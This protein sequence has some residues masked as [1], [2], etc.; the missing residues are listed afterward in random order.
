MQ[1][2]KVPI[3]NFQYGEVSPSLI[4]RT[5]SE[6]YNSSA[7]RV[8]NFFLR[9][10][11]G[12][13]KR[14]GTKHIYT[15]D[16]TLNENACTITVADYANIAVGATITLTTS[17]GVE[18][19]FTAEAAGASDPASS[20]GFRP[21]T[22]NNTTADNIYTTINAHASFTVANPSAAVIT[23]TETSPSP[24]GFLTAKSSDGT[25]LAVT[26]ES[27]ARTQ[28]ARLVPFIFSDDERYI[29]SLENAKI[30][31]FSIDTSDAVT[32]VSTI[33][34][35]TDSA[36]VPFADTKLHELV[37]AQSGDNM[38]ITHQSFPIKKLV[39]TSLTAFE[40]QTFEFASNGDSTLIFQPYSKFHAAGLTI[41]PSAASGSGITVTASAA[42]FTSNHVGV[43][44]RYHNSEIL[45]TGFTNATT[46]TGTVQGNLQQQLDINALRTTEGSASIEV[47]HVDHGLKVGDG[48]IVAE[49]A[50]IATLAASNIN[51]TR[52]ITAIVDENR[53]RFAA[54]S[55]TADAS[56][57][58]GGAPKITTHAATTQFSEQS[59]SLVRG[60][61]ACVSFH[62]NRL[63]FGGTESQP[64]TV[65][66]SKSN[67]FFNFDVGTAADDDAI[68]LV[69]SIGEINT[70]RHIVSNRD[71][72]VF[73][74]T[75]EFYVPSFQNS[76]IT[77]TNAQIKRQTPFGS[78]FV[79]PFVFDGAT[80]Y[81]QSSGKS[82]S[83]YI[84]AD[85]VNAYTSQS[86]ST[87]SSHLIKTPHQMVVLQGSLD[88]PESYLFAVNSDGTIAVFNSNPA[89]KKAGWTE[90]TT[91]GIFQSVCVVDTNLYVTAWYDT[92]AG[93]KK[94]YLMQ[95]D[96]T[97]NLDL[98]RDYVTSAVGTIAGVSSDWVN[99]A[100]LDVISDTDYVGQF[101]MA[102][103]KIVTTTREDVPINTKLEIG[104]TFPVE[105]KTNPIDAA[106]QNG[107]LTGE[108]RSVNKVIVDMNITGSI[109]INGSNLIIRQT[110]DDFSLGRKSFT[111]KKEFRLLGYSKDPQVTITQEAPLSLQVNGIVA[112]VT[113]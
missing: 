50:T 20:T 7:Q 94:L 93:T 54:A 66:S 111:G 68:E 70:I 18:V 110:T 59:Y 96:A 42:Y 40:L 82:I 63:W 83:Q 74:S 8:Q 97:K 92:G 61:P 113:F 99:G 30:R 103:N 41:D 101:T 35:D 71:L 4:A 11:G 27:L 112:E 106:V 107:S 108:P 67:D 25:R 76:P 52:A 77:P 5:D 39:R 46:V 58:G 36:A 81:C 90:F 51:G 57:D 98:S 23:V 60:Y 37:Y 72:Q 85:T 91:N 65:W 14:S 19:V 22:N 45:I 34:Q 33:T 48:I 16:I 2:V 109:A 73:T 75:S 44:L 95:F 87:V 1:K 32:L 38:F 104:Y 31:V 21:N 105:L 6:I 84:F 89:E 3:Q 24:T 62:E 56:I 29:V 80:L 13:I 47:T 15:Y 100:V 10:E 102:S 86:V 12:V 79:R 78:N 43:T 49:A 28:Q 26:S 69:A 55:G 17:A 53:Y 64:D 9:A 88:R